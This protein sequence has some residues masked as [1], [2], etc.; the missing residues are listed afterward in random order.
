VVGAYQ[1]PSKP[2]KLHRCLPRRA[3]DHGARR[4]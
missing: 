2:V 4:L 1:L 3:S